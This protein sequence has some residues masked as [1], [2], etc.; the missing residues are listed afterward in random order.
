MKAITLTLL[1]TLASCLKGMGPKYANP[2]DALMVITDTNGVLL[3]SVDFDTP[4]DSALD[5][6]VEMELEMRND[7]T[8]PGFAFPGV[9]TMGGNSS[10]YFKTE[11]TEKRCKSDELLPPGESCKFK[12][13]FSKGDGVIGVKNEIINFYTNK[14]IFTVPLNGEII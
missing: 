7:G 12:I 1:F 9:Q 11:I 6:V 3:T 8:A 4:V 13:I 5:S 10:L 14:R 2:D